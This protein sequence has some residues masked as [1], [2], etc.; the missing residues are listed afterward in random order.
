MKVTRVRVNDSSSTFFP[1]RQSRGLLSSPGFQWISSACFSSSTTN[2][3][4]TGWQGWQGPK[5]QVLVAWVMAGESYSHA[6]LLNEG[7][8]R[9]LNACLP[10]SLG[11]HKNDLK[12]ALPPY[13]WE[14]CR[15]F[16]LCL[17][18]LL[19]GSRGPFYCPNKLINS[20]FPP[21]SWAKVLY[22]PHAL[23]WETGIFSHVLAVPAVI[24]L[25]KAVVFSKGKSYFW[26]VSNGLGCSFGFKLNSLH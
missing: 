11:Q 9:L 22:K 19:G 20:I 25:T 2:E 24:W 13:D 12:D 26:I 15:Y 23:Y 5:H 6:E 18:I 21:R 1:S 16:P 14:D 10:R 4:E 17:E 7:A 8:H 3:A